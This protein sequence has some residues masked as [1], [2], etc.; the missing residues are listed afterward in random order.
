MHTERTAEATPDAQPVEGSPAG[1]IVFDMHA[2]GVDVAPRVV[3]RVLDLVPSM[4]PSFSFEQMKPAGVDALVACVVGDPLGTL[5]RAPRDPWAAVRRQFDSLERQAA[6]AG[7]VIV[8]NSSELNYARAQKLPGIVLG[9]EGADIL[10]PDLERADWLHDRGVRMIG[11]VHYSDNALGTI[12]T[13]VCGQPRSRQVRRG[14]RTA[15]LTELGRAAIS[16]MNRLGIVV[17]LAHADRAT[18]LAAC[19]TSSAPVVS[20]HT[21][22]A[23]LEDLARYISDEEIAAIAATGGLIGLWPFHMGHHGMADASDFARHALHIASRVGVGHLGIGTDGNGGPATMAKYR[24][25]QDHSIIRA[26]LTAAG[27][28]D[29]DCAAIMGGNALRVFTA[30]CG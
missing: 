19:A 4:D 15:G 17:D 13:T 22:A 8:R 12:G 26:G 27:F 6:A 10:G 2:H 29:A 16:R 23:A 30:V 1:H 14:L 20:S 5:W 18:T 11:L 21:A 24:G 9:V 25:P 7:A 28:S 3:R